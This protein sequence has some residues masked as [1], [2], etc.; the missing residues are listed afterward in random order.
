MRP[1]PG[2][3]GNRHHIAGRDRHAGRD[4][5][6]CGTG[7]GNQGNQSRFPWAWILLALALLGGGAALG[8]YLK[9]SRKEEASAT[10]PPDAYRT[11]PPIHTSGFPPELA[12]RYDR[13]AFVGRGGLGQVFSAVRRDD[14]RTVAVKIPVSYDEATGKTF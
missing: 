9:R 12:G 3:N 6:R 13:V 5:N 7:Q 4:G 2:S 11:M 8:I 1:S 10:I 14:G